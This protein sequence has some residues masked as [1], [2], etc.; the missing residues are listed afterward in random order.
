MP[1]A[2]PELPGVSTLLL[3]TPVA[4]DPILLHAFARRDRPLSVTDL[5]RAMCGTGVHLSDVLDLLTGELAAGRLAVRGFRLDTNGRP[6]G[7]CLYELSEP[8]WE[9][10]EAD[11][12][13]L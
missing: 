2:T 7:P 6:F 9:A 13:A 1:P 4:A 11:R 8:G 10:V 5:L 12:L 3:E